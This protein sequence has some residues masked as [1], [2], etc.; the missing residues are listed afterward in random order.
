MKK[1]TAVVKRKTGE[2]DIS[3]NLALGAQEAGSIQSGVGFLDHMLTLWS[4]HG[5]M[6]LDLQATGDVQVDFHH[7]VEDIGI[8][9]GQALLAAVGDKQ[10]ISRYG[11]AFVPM[12]E[13]LA[14]VSL[15]FGGRGF[16]VFEVEIPSPK[17][18]DFD[19]E[20]VVEFLRA[21]AFN[22]GITLHVRMLSGTNSH[23]IIEA[24]FKAFG[25]ALKEATALDPAIK[26]VLSTKGTI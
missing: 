8:C 20:L 3:L 23:H 1:R 4:R 16:L 5:F 19:T 26:G 2:T 11:T 13:A 10:G 12:D 14:M 22:A 18:G 21:V 15:D 9:L 17:V 6:K 7:T 25:R 24:I